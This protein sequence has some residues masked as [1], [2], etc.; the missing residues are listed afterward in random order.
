MSLGAHTRIM[1]ILNITPDS[2]SDGGRYFQQD[3]ALAH[4]EEMIA[5]GA[6][7]L[8]VGGESSR[9]FSDPV[10]EE[11][12]ACRVLPVIEY[13]ARRVPVPI[14][15]DTTKSGIARRAIDAGASIINDI[16]SLISDPEIGIIAA[17]HD[18]LLI[19]MHMKGTPKTM[20]VAPAYDDLID[21]IHDFLAD[22]ISRAAAC[23]VGLS[24][25]IIDPGIGF[26]KTVSHNLRLIRELSRFNTLKAP[27][28]IGSSRKAFIRKILTSETGSEPSPDHPDVMH[29]SQAAVAAAVLSGAHIVRVH[30]VAAVRATVRI[31]DAVKNAR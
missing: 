14:S 22:A 26:G 1:G 10:T 20:Q 30:D 2:F 11:Q 31:V 23:G 15:I 7:I 4:A 16:S 6:D 3:R 28:L 17:N 27:I 24:R 8:D 21:E 9:P 19:L 5:Q 12:E 18:V 29:G 13:L 25:M